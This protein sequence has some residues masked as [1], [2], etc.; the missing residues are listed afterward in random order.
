MAIFGV[1]ASYFSEGDVTRKFLS[2]NVAC[3]N[4]SNE[5]APVLHKLMKTIKVGDI[6]YIKSYPYATGLEI[7]AVGVVQDDNVI[8]LKDVGEACLK[9]K[10]TWTG[11]KKLGKIGDRYNVR[12]LSIYEELNPDIQ[13]KVV[14]LLRLK[15]YNDA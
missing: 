3:I 13:K 4:W 12:T 5:D 8:F 9:V 11:S 7:K 14:D 6:I 1:G 2:N 15:S 10:W